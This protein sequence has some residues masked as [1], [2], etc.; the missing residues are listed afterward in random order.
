MRKKEVHSDLIKMT[1]WKK[2]ASM[3]YI[4][5]TQA[6]VVY[7]SRDILIKT[8]RKDCKIQSKKHDICETDLFYK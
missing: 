6:L 8:S 1:R 2:K 7:F 3:K 4:Q 5:F